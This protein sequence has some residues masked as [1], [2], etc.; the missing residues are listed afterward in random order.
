MQF[1]ARILTPKGKVIYY[2]QELTQPT[3]GTSVTEVYDGLE[4][5]LLGFQCVLVSGQGGD[6]WNYAS[7][8][9]SRG[10]EDPTRL[11]QILATGYFDLTTPLSW[12][13]GIQRWQTD[14]PGYVRR[15]TG[16]DP[17]AGG[18]HTETVPTSTRWRLVSA[19]YTLVTDATVANRRFIV[20]GRRNDIT[21][22]ASA[23]NMVQTASTTINYSVAHWG[24][25]SG[26]NNGRVQVNWP[27]RVFLSAGDRIVTNVANFQGGDDFGAPEFLVEEWYE[28]S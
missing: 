14:G 1:G 5:F 8:G 18:N 4:G 2:R 17:G 25:D 16:A 3:A 15:V 26:D 7:V 6:R 21:M 12:P 20:E 13:N 24:S 23:A 10:S 28:R 11:F 27:A 19:Y 9:L 22:F